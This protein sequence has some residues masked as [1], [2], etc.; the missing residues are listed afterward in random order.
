AKTFFNLSFVLLFISIGDR[1][2]PTFEDVLFGIIEIRLVLEL[3]IVTFIILLLGEILPKLYASKNNLRFVH[4][5]ANPIQILD[6]LLSP[7]NRPMQAITLY[8][9][10][11]LGKHT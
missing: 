4:L 5:M 9:H 11:R 6:K 1:L 8:F 7:I 3:V 10:K 2:F